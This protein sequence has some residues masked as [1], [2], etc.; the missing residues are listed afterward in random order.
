[1]SPDGTTLAPGAND[2]P[3][4]HGVQP[5]DFSAYMQTGE[6]AASTL[7]AFVEGVHCGGCV[8]KIERALSAEPDVR[9]ARVNLSTRRLSMTWD[10]SPA[11]GNALNVHESR[12]QTHH[13]APC[14]VTPR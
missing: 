12:H 4:G 10:G 8:N 7:H 6:D 5:A 11:R 2:L 3:R 9:N 1:M 14:H 13:P